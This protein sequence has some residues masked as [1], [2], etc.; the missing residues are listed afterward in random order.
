MPYVTIGNIDVYYEIHGPPDAPPLVLIG[1][2]AS[3]RWIWFRQ[4]PAFKEKYKCIVFDNRGAG[5]SSKPDIPYTMEM[6]AADTVGLMD[7]LDIENAHILGI[8]MGGLIAQQVAISSPEKV[9]SLILVSTNFGGPNSIP[10]DDRTMALLVALPTETISKE[11]ARNMRYR[12]TFSEQF[13]RENRDVIEKIDEWAEKHPTPLIAQVHQSLAVGDFNAEDEVKKITS[14]TLIIH[15]DSDRAVPTKN[16]ELLDISIPQ[17]RL[18]L[19]K[20]GSHFSIIEKYE[21]FNSTV[22]DFIDEMER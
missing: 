3:Y 2:W 10:M 8:S 20:G 17:S 19:I 7:A 16:G 12:A 11:Q 21:E 9:R 15:G 4:V 13:L 1:G 22:M 6:F 18:F 14:P 5:R